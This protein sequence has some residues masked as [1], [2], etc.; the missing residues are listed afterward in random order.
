MRSLH[1]LK[2]P[3]KS[4]PQVSAPRKETRLQTA[5]ARPQNIICR[6]KG[7]KTDNIDEWERWESLN[8]FLSLATQH[9]KTLSFEDFEKQ[10]AKLFRNKKYEGPMP[11][12][13]CDSGIGHGN[14][15]YS[16]E[17]NLIKIGTEAP[18]SSLYHELA[19][20][21]GCLDVAVA[22]AYYKRLPWYKKYWT[23]P[24]AIQV[25]LELEAYVV[26]K[27]RHLDRGW[28]QLGYELAQNLNFARQA[29]EKFDETASFE[30]CNRYFTSREELTAELSMAHR[31]KNK[32]YQ[33]FLHTLTPSDSK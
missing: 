25:S 26:S 27:K 9:D 28:V 29:S 2:S 23:R 6:F 10:L 21:E 5:I 11:G 14:A 19:H 16:S 24:P 8:P 7:S 18:I 20:Y 30:D 32:A 31:M 12:L 15:F 4:I 17:D 1:F 33:D 3:S 22:Q 13:V